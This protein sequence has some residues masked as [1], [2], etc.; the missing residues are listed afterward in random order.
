MS[1]Y[2]RRGDLIIGLI[3][4]LRNELPAEPGGEAHG[5]GYTALAWTRDGKTWQRERAPFMPRND[6]PETFDRAMTWAD[7][8]LPVGDEV[9]IYYG[10]YAHG[11]KV[12]RF[13]ERQ[14][15]LA[16]MKRDRYVSRDAASTAE[17]M[18]RTPVLALDGS[19]LSVNADVTG[20][21]RVGVL[22]AEGK[23]I[24]GFS[25][26]DCTPL[27]GDSVSHELQWKRP[28]SDLRGT[29]VQLQF[30][31]RDAQLYAFEVGS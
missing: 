26:D 11:H 17:G 2:L 14:I 22:D 31:L 16:R 4:V 28:L 12:E 7:C 18:L 25:A 24:D 1:G 6:K 30:T 27:R 9:F 8:Q 3:K 5:I 29:P 10:A 13:K 20:E 19:K 21:M 23:P 15:G